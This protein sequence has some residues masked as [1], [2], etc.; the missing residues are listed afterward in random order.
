M[1]TF[2]A[3]AFMVMF[4]VNAN[5]K[6]LDGNTLQ[7]WCFS[8]DAGNQAACLGYV[9]GVA[10]VLISEKSSELTQYKACIPAI[11]TTQV[12]DTAKQYFDAHRQSGNITASDLVAM[13]L[14]GNAVVDI[15][16]RLQRLP[17]PGE[18]LL[19][20]GR[21]VDMGGKELDHAVAA[22][23]AGAEVQ[24]VAP[25]G[26][27]QAARRIR[28]VFAREGLDPAL[29]VTVDAPTDE[30]VIW[31]AE[32]GENAIVSTAA[33]AQR[34]RPADLADR[35]RADPRAFGS[36]GGPAERDGTPGASL[37]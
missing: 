6:F 26:Q 32:D 16:Y 31:V 1:R 24:L 8:E 7:D 13:A 11:E 28:D 15:A 19:A 34:L 9:I 22:R 25:V 3:V 30:S 18:T 17:R 20:S 33:A 12:V 21:T 4:T 35:E 27:D 37:G 36:V 23:R 29:L 14:S 2:L 10:D 5:A